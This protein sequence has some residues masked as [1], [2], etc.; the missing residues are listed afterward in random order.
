MK[1]Y[2]NL[3]GAVIGLIAATMAWAQ[4]PPA[5]QPSQPA[6]QTPPPAAM[7]GMAGPKSPEISPD[8]AVTFRL[9]APDA[10][11]VAVSGNW[12][13]GFMS[14]P[15][16]MTKGADGIW[17]LAVNGLKP[18]IWTYNFVVDGVR[19]LDPGNVNVMRDGI[20][21]LS[22]VMIPGAGSEL[23][24]V[25]DVPH[26]AV[27]QIWYPSPSLGVGQRRMYVYTPAGYESGAQRYPVFYLLHGGGGDE[28]AWD[29]LGRAREIFDNLIAAGKARPMIVVMTNG[30]WDQSAAPGVTRQAESSFA[31]FTNPNSD[32]F[33]KLIDNML[34]FSDSLAADVI[35][36]VDKTYRTIPDRDH[37]AIAGLSMGGGQTIWAGFRHLD[38]FS[39]VAS[40]SGG[41]ILFPGAVKVVPT[42]PGAPMIPGRGMALNVSALPTV[43]PN[44]DA[45][46]NQKLHLLYFSC[47]EN[48]GL[49]TSNQQFMDWLTSRGVR[50]DKLILPGYAHEWPF[51]RI[52]LAD[53]TP[54][55]FN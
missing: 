7:F 12:Q 27:Q 18:E 55:L 45:S 30:N 40:F 37:R 33:N 52:S 49:L 9:R 47:G 31:A 46:V 28:D 3:V 29:N 10:T 5:Q 14:P 41:L 53:L 21:F 34:S 6:A 20:R 17:Q 16:P 11:A 36:F 4:Q 2:P 44:L 39:Y 13:P 15:L 8:G 51:W 42:P 23:Y 24:A 50:Y 35:P 19:I 38:Q 32:S 54:K 22:Y 48:D 1:T 43:F 25:N 26:G